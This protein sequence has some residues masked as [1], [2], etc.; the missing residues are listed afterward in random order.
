MS[1]VNFDKKEINF[2]IVYYGPPLGGKTT[3]L[4]YLHKI[5]PA[6]VRGDLTMLS[7]QQDRTLYF[8]FL[9][10]RSKVIKGFVSR[11]QLYTVPGQPIYDRTRQIVLTG[12][13]GVVF[14]ADSEWSKMTANVESL[15]NLQ[16]NLATHDRSL[17]TLPYIIQL[18]KRDLTDIAPVPYMTY[19]LNQG[20]AQAECFESVA[21]EGRG[22]DTSLNTICK[23]V[24]AQFIAENRMQ[25]ELTTTAGTA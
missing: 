4:A 18:N 11:F 5:M 14:V 25:V 13:D 8:D 12:A 3:N 10:L 9:P 21:T 2:K 20:T 1:F 22:V 24:M 23:M 6:S 17:E 16:T 15:E 19:L 7:T